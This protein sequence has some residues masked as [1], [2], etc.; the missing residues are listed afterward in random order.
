MW[1]HGMQTDQAVLAVFDLPQSG[2]RGQHSSTI[3]HLIA[4]VRKGLPVQSFTR[5][6]EALDV[7]ED[8]L[9]RIVHLPR[10]TFARRKAD[11]RL[12]P[13]ESDQLF[14]VARTLVL[15]AEVLGSIEQARQWLQRSNHSL[16][17]KPPLELLDTDAGTTLVQAVLT[18]L[19]Y[20]VFG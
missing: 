15:A 17:D 18:R 9:A 5:L 11:G 20:G 2:G 16:G 3:D 7:G 19:D 10:R 4:L 14:R 8:S 13:I 12:T 1:Q 6:V